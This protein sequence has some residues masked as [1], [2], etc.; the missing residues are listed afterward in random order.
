MFGPVSLFT[1]SGLYCTCSLQ[2]GT[3][4]VSFTFCFSFFLS[5][6]FLKDILHISRH[7]RQIGLRWCS[8]TKNHD[9]SSYNVLCRRAY[10]WV[11][12]SLLCSFYEWDDD[13]VLLLSLLYEL[14]KS[15]ANILF[16]KENTPKYV[17]NNENRQIELWCWNTTKNLIKFGKLCQLM[18]NNI[19][20]KSF[21]TIFS[22]LFSNC[23]RILIFVPIIIKVL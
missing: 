4:S 6:F 5:L 16:D 1:L 11:R 23:W 12:R 17:H 13:T 15:H 20:M 2:V 22:F 8:C 18:T 3:F 14:W 10:V 19:R 7:Q 9:Y 21:W